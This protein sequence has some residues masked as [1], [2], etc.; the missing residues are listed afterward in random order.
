MNVLRGISVVSRVFRGCFGGG[1]L[2]D[3]YECIKGV[4]M[5]FKRDSS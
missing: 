5:V 2:K 4:F 3:F 1:C